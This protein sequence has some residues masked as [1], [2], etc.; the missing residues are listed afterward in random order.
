M[1]DTAKKTANDGAHDVAVH[2]T[3]P[4]QFVQEVRRETSKVT[5][6][7]WKETWVTTVMV[8]VMVALTMLFFFV[9]DYVLGIGVQWLLTAGTGA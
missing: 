3:G 1:A 8:F 6:P 2:R 5:W 7:T 9:V 4:I